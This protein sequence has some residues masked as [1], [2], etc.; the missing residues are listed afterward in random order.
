[1][2]A[3]AAS[4]KLD[5][6]K[7]ATDAAVALAASTVIT[8]IIASLAAAGIISMNLAYWLLGLAWLVADSLRS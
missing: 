6:R 2:A 1:M 3:M 8:L 4:A 5:F 7:V